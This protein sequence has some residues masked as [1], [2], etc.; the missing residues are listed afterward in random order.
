[1]I[2]KEYAFERPEN[3]SDDGSKFIPIEIMRNKLE[4]IDQF[5]YGKT[6]I[7][8]AGTVEDE[9]AAVDDYKWD[10]ECNVDRRER[11]RNISKKEMFDYW[12]DHFVYDNNYVVLI[13]GFHNDIMSLGSGV[14]AQLPLNVGG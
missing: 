14:C 11:V 1:M 10:R 5:T 4:N 8:C 9:N 13:E 6:K 3:F 7:I 2:S 12:K